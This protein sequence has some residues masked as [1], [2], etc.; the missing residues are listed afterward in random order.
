M[1][2]DSPLSSKAVVERVEPKGRAYQLLTEVMRLYNDL[3]A[4]VVNRTPR[5]YGIDIICHIGG[6]SYE[7]YS[8]GFKTGDLIFIIA[9]ESGIPFTVIAPVEQTAFTVRKVKLAPGVTPREIGFVAEENAPLE[10]G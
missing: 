3:R 2:S 10:M 8:L 4:E 7:V 6:A 1:N 5:E 9:R